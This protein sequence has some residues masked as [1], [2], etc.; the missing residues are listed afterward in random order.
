M[1]AQTKIMTWSGRVLSG[2]IG[3]MLV[4]SASMKLK[5]AP[6]VAEQMVGKLG[7]PQEVI[8]ALGVVEISCVVLYLVPQTAALGAVLLTGYLGGATATH[9]RVGEA[10]YAPVI[11]GVLVWSGLFLRDPRI[12]ALIPLRSN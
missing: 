10:F 4:F 8:V 9:V 11:L 5:N 1:G 2:L 6:E 12:R 3:L 7:Y